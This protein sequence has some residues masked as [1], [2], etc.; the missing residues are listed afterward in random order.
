MTQA[1]RNTVVVFLF[2]LV[3]DVSLRGRTSMHVTIP[4]VL[5]VLAG[6]L[7]YA[8]DRRRLHP[9]SAPEA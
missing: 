9:S 4:A 1:L 3:V 5:G 7:T 2:A 8:R 6:V